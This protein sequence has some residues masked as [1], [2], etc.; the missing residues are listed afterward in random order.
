M[1]GEKLCLTL[2]LLF[3]LIGFWCFLNLVFDFTN[4]SFLL[5][6]EFYTDPG[7]K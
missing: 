1:L 4:L 5:F 2:T 6:E 7:E 3:R